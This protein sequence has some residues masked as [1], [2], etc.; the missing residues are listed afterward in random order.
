M[1]SEA[2]APIT[3]NAYYS[4]RHTV[5]Q[6]FFAFLLQIICI[7]AKSFG[8]YAFLNVYTNIYAQ[9]PS[10]RCRWRIAPTDASDASQAVRVSVLLAFPFGEGVDRARL[11]RSILQEYFCSCNIRD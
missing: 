11:S 10:E 5:L 9:K 4:T 2:C 3:C 6:V 7:F 8:F 1:R